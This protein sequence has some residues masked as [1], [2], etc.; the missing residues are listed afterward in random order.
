M[1]KNPW[2]PVVPTAEG[3]RAVLWTSGWTPGSPARPSTTRATGMPGHSPFVKMRPED[4]DAGAMD[5][6]PLAGVRR[7]RHHR[8]IA[9]R[10]SGS[11]WVCATR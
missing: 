7:R 6:V 1:I 11:R 4:L 3:K 2:K 10:L 9:R 8:G 5:G